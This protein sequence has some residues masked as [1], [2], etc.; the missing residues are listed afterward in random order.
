MGLTTNKYLVYLLYAILL[1]WHS[2]T[3]NLSLTESKIINIHW[4]LRKVFRTQLCSRRYCLVTLQ[5]KGRQPVGSKW[6]IFNLRLR[7]RNLKEQS[8]IQK[9]LATIR[10]LRLPST[11]WEV[12]VFETCRPLNKHK[13]A[14]NIFRIIKKKPVKNVKWPLRYSS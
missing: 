14:I 2:L 1:A 9:I 7:P 10:F 12:T 8:N 13:N 6:S 4:L 3:L 5:L 11:V